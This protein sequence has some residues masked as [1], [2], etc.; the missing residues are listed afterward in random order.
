MRPD[1][2]PDSELS[3][4]LC[5]TR[6]TKPQVKSVIAV[7][8][9][10]WYLSSVAAIFWW[11]CSLCSSLTPPKFGPRKSRCS[12]TC[13]LTQ[14][15]YNTRGGTAQSHSHC[16]AASPTPPTDKTVKNFSASVILVPS[17]WYCSAC[18][19]CVSVNISLFIS[20]SKIWQ[21]MDPVCCNAS[22]VWCKALTKCFTKL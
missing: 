21:N 8:H 20:A 4:R 13:V 10:P 2:R 5:S 18:R 14:T 9:R 3:E 6:R 19:I 1:S 16:Q 12:V 15:F 7:S 17:S 11:K 22:D